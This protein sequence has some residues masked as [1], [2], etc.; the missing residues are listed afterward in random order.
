MN[1]TRGI[2]ATAQKVVIY[3]P[4]GVGKSTLA[5]QFPNPLFIDT[6]GSTNNMDVARLDPPSSWTMLIN[7]I[8][9]V[10]A[11]PTV[12]Q[13]L[14]IDTIDWAER[15]AIESICAQYD[16]KGIEDFGWGAGYTYL[17]EELGRL[18][19]KLQ[20]LVDMGINIVLTAHSQLKKFE[21]PDELG[22]YDRYELKLANKKQM[23]LHL[24]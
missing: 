23:P 5:A 11:N 6:E 10:K 1:I 22:T 2:K 3:G 12:C 24:V 17:A 14:I 13:T 9:F 16:K 20:E 8:A 18:L 7:Q 4:E 15:L 21:L 19:N